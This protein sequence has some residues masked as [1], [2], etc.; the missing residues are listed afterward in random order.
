MIEED[1]T[2]GIQQIFIYLAC[3]VIPVKSGFFRSA[4][5][6]EL[7]V[8]IFAVNFRTKCF[9]WSGSQIQNL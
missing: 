1:I 5:G 4:G 6:K 7:Y 9:S 2:R 8:Y 3:T